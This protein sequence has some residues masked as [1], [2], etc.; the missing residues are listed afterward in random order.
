[1]RLGYRIVKVDRLFKLFDELGWLITPLAHLNEVLIR[2]EVLAHNSLL[3]VLQSH[4]DRS[5]KF[6]LV[7]DGPGTWSHFTRNLAKLLLKAGQLTLQEFGILLH[8]G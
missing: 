7:D 5:V 4:A 8:Q 1:V 3:L 2:F 6:A